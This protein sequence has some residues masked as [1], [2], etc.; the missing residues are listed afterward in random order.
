MIYFFF[1][2][3]LNELMECIISEEVEGIFSLT[4]TVCIVIIINGQSNHFCPFFFLF[5]MCYILKAEFLLIYH[6][7][8]GFKVISLVSYVFKLWTFNLCVVSLKIQL[9]ANS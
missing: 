8:T 1:R 9:S 5:F 2:S 3:F 7:S 4:A 6:F